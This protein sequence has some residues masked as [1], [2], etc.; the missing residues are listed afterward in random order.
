M[1]AGGW[2][3]GLE[4]RNASHIYSNLFLNE[5]FDAWFSEVG[6]LNEHA[7]RPPT[8]IPNF[9]SKFFMAH[10][11]YHARLQCRRS[12][13]RVPGYQRD[14]LSRLRRTFFGVL[15]GW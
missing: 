11:G 12:E 15:G 2:W 14:F 8:Y 10:Y 1:L 3:S 5:P 9:D 6:L 7:S 13:V 4:S